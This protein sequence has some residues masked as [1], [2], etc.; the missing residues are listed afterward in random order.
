[1]ETVKFYGSKLGSETSMSF[2]SVDVIDPC[3][4]DWLNISFEFPPST[5]NV[6]KINAYIFHETRTNL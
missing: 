3:F 1:M 6:T 2:K 4:Q 5:A